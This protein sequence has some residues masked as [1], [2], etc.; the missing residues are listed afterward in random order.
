MLKK[1]IVLILAVCIL[2]CTASFAQAESEEKQAPADKIVYE[3]EHLT[4]RMGSIAVEGDSV[5]VPLSF[6]ATGQRSCIMTADM[7]EAMF[8]D[9]DGFEALKNLKQINGGITVPNADPGETTECRFTW[10]ST[11][12][13]DRSFIVDILEQLGIIL[14][15]ETIELEPEGFPKDLTACLTILLCEPE[16]DIMITW[17]LDPDNLTDPSNYSLIRLR[18]ASAD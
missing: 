7:T 2:F 9:M 18:F 1:T 15:P 10:N 13:Y 5:T 17:P 12:T 6:N 11:G 16:A 3:N 8:T 4:I 14:E